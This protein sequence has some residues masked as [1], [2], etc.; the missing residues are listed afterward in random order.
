MRRDYC[1]GRTIIKKNGL[2]WTHGFAGDFVSGVASRYKIQAIPNAYFITPDQHVRR[3]PVTFLIGPDGKMLGHDLSGTDLEAVREALESPKLFPVSALAA[4]TA[5]ELSGRGPVAGWNHGDLIVSAPHRSI[6][7]QRLQCF[8]A[9][10][11]DTKNP[12]IQ[13]RDTPGTALILNRY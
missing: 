8:V 13:S 2:N 7:R 11:D 3:I 9:G 6:L 10:V 12:G 1:S 4:V 5:Y